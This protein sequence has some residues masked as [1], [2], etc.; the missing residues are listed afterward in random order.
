MMPRGLLQI[1][2]DES[3][4]HTSFTNRR[5]YAFD[6]TQPHV[7]AG[8]D[9]GNSRLEKVGIAAERPAPSLYNVITGQDVSA[10]I[11]CDFLRQPA[12]L[13][14]RSDE[15]EKATTVVSA[16]RC[17]RVVAYI[18]RSQIGGTVRSDDF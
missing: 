10:Y 7:P 1:L 5:R 8:E 18:D 17:A 4:C 6:R 13:C 2:V 12:S 3:D 11:A 15:H 14:V 9:T 16:H